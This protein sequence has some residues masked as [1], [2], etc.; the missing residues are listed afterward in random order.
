MVDQ[1]EIDQAM[2]MLAIK[3]AFSCYVDVHKNVTQ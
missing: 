1:V 3:L 2:K